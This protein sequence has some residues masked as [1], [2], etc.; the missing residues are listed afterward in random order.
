MHIEAWIPFPLCKTNYLYSMCREHCR[1]LSTQN[2]HIWPE[3]ITEQPGF[4][5]SLLQEGFSLPHAA[6]PIYVCVYFTRFHYNWFTFCPD[7][8]PARRD[9][10]STQ[11]LTQTDKQQYGYIM[12]FVYIHIP[13]GAES[14]W[15]HIFPGFFYI[16][17]TVPDRKSPHQWFSQV[18]MS[19]WSS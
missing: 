10:Y 17:L 3:A 4:K 7:L 5:Y 12:S 1:T 19:P 16:G 14:P 11:I 8:P 15:V 18:N 13:L 6:N 2:F 9:F